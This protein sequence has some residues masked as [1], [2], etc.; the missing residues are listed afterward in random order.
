[1]SWQ[2]GSDELLQQREIAITKEC[3]VE[4]GLECE[5]KLQICPEPIQR[6]A[7]N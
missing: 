4:P 2:L 3:F 1:M 7:D 6:Q 5:A